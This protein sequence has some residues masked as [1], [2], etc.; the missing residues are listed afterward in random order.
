M[1]APGPTARPFSA[2]K[3]SVDRRFD[4]R[5]PANLDAHITVLTEPVRA[6]AIRITDISK[7]GVALSAPFVLTP[8]DIVQLRIGDSTLFGFVAHA[9]QDG[10]AF[11]AGVELQ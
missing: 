7:S 6:G 9:S 4:E 1:V 5:H 10:N 8:E 2:D 11:Q 3:R